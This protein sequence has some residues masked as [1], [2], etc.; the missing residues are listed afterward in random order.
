MKRERRLC[1]LIDTQ[2]RAELRRAF[3]DRI[4]VGESFKAICEEMKLPWI[5]TCKELGIDDSHLA[6]VYFPKKKASSNVECEC[7]AEL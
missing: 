4:V 1:F 2:G 6:E 7:D 3:L 5:M